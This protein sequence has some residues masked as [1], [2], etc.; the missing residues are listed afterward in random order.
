MK[1]KVLYNIYLY[2]TMFLGIMATIILMFYL[3]ANYNI[4]TITQQAY[5]IISIVVELLLTAILCNSFADKL[6]KLK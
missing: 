4:D 5:L 1:K 6:N 3:P 2:L